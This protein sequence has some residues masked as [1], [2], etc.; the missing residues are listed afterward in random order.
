MLFIYWRDSVTSD[1]VRECPMSGLLAC[2]GGAAVGLTGCADGYE[3][4]LCGACAEDYYFAVDKS[5]AKCSGNEAA[6]VAVAVVAFVI[7]GGLLVLITFSAHKSKSAHI[8]SWRRKIFD[9]IWDV[10]KVQA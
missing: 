10:A 8:Q 9:E 6:V 5:C 4:V 7:G 2:P 1:A 3:T